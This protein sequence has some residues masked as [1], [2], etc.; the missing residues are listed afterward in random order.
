MRTV[1]GPGSRPSLPRAES[2]RSDRDHQP[3][4]REW[5]AAPP[6]RPEAATDRLRARTARSARPL[7]EKARTRA[8]R[9]GNHRS[10]CINLPAGRHHRGPKEIHSA[11]WRRRSPRTIHPAATP[12]P[13]AHPVRSRTPA[14]RGDAR[15]FTMSPNRCGS[16]DTKLLGCDCSRAVSV[17][18]RGQRLTARIA[19]QPDPAC[20]GAP[21]ISPRPESPCGDG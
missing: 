15:S 9:L 17:V 3:P 1:A 10:R 2:P 8:E 21:P 5:T 12:L 18:R 20:A 6:A 14:Q 19:R 16:S 13:G 4:S 11:R 7:R